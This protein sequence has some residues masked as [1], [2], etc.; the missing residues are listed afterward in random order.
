M[1]GAEVAWDVIL[2][3]LGPALIYLSRVLLWKRPK[4]KAAELAALQPSLGGIGRRYWV[5][6]LGT[7]IPVGALLFALYKLDEP[8]WAPRVMYLFMLFFGAY[9]L[10]DGLFALFTNVFPATTRY[11][12]DRFVY[13]GEEELRWVALLQSALAVF[14]LA[15]GAM[16]LLGTL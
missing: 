11:N 13:D 9:A 3:L 15:A 8:F 7:I 14:Y 6:L 1:S 2:L 5:A 12:L 10:V 16:R 4:H